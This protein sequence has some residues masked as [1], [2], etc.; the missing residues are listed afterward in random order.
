[1]TVKPLSNAINAKGAFERTNVRLWRFRRQILIAAF[2]IKAEFE[3]GVLL[4]LNEH[5][6]KVPKSKDGKIG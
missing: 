2:A 3:H 4:S 5:D 6:Q 1:M